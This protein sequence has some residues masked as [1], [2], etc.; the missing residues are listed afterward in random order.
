ETGVECKALNVDAAP[1]AAQGLVNTIDEIGRAVDILPHALE[2]TI[3]EKINE[4]K[5]DVRKWRYSFRSGDDD[6]LPGRIP[7]FEEVE[8][9]L[10]KAKECQEFNHEEAS[11]NNQV[12]LRLLES[13]FE[14][15]IGGQCDSFNAVSCATARPH[16][17]FK[18]ASTPVKMID[19]CIYASTDGDAELSASIRKFCSTTPTRAVNHTDFEPISMRPLL[20]S[21]ETKRPGV[22]WDT[23][24][25]QIGAW[26]AAQ[27]S[28]LRWAVGEKILR[29]RAEEGIEIPQTDEEQ[30]AFEANKLAALSTLGFIPGI[31]VQGHRWLLVLSTYEDGKT[32]LWADH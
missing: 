26:H 8:K 28:F 16:R 21:I 9:L 1:N 20:L 13:I 18:L 3:S 25:L 12:H 17:E 22:N 27:W 29:Q 11:W 23:A 5:L 19:M 10:R 32:K 14:E 24:Q 7:T 6:G 2:P 4:R 15:P 30:Q 31:I